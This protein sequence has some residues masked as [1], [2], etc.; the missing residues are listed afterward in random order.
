LI[1]TVS[2]PPTRSGGT[3]SRLPP[4]SRQ[5]S[6][7]PLLY[8]AY[9]ASTSRLFGLSAQVLRFTVFDARAARARFTLRLML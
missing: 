8:D 7:T 5:A 3:I 2:I 1:T 9:R 4:A 6:Q